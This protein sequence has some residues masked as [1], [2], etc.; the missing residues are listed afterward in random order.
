M[1]KQEQQVENMDGTTSI[2]ETNQKSSK[3][4]GTLNKMVSNNVTRGVGR[5]IMYSVV[6]QVVNNVM[7]MIFKR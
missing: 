4:K 1:N 2:H 7:R 6:H 5:G 3:A